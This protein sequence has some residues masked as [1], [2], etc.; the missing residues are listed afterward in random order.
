MKS[1]IIYYSYSGNTDKVAH[2]FARVL[3]EKGEVKI[4]R[5]KPKDEIK[6]FMAQ[7]KAAFTRKRAILEDGVTF[8]ITPYDFVLIGSPVWAFAPTPAINTYLDNIFC[9]RGK[10]YLVFLTSGSGV[11]VKKCFNNITSVLE[12]KGASKIDELNIQDRKINDENF[13]ISAFKKLL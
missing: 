4:Q 9:V 7:C 3:K 6:T 13:I 11:G 10:R 2:I 12:S 5:L 1:L 8:D